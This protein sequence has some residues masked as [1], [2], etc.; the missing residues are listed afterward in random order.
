MKEGIIDIVSSP[1]RKLEDAM[2]RLVLRGVFPKNEVGGFD[3]PPVAAAEV[4]VIT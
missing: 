3:E 2:A 1:A 4:I